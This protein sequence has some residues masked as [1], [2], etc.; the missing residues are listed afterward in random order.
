MEDIRRLKLVGNIQ[1]VT[2]DKA[3]DFSCQLLEVLVKHL[4]IP[5]GRTSRDRLQNGSDHI[6]TGNSSIFQVRICYDCLSIISN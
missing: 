6:Q 4:D 5:T 2:L 1:L 3:Q